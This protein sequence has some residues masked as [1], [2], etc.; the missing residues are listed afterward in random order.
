VPPGR[1]TFC[2]STCYVESH[3]YRNMSGESK[4][5]H[6]ESIKRYRAKRRQLTGTL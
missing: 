1:R 6:L 2:S 5:K 4:R 3:K